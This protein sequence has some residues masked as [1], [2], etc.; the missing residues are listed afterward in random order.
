MRRS[1]LKISKKKVLVVIM[2]VNLPKH[3]KYNVFILMQVGF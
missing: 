1:E 2:V 3:Q